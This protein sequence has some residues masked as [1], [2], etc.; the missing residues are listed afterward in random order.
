MKCSNFQSCIILLIFPLSALCAQGVDYNSTVASGYN[1]T[2]FTKTDGSLWVMGRND[3]GQL[4]DGT[5]TDR[6]ASVKIVDANIIAVAAG[7]SHSL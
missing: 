5:T 6:N 3:Y 2:L 1:H 7:Q 4:G